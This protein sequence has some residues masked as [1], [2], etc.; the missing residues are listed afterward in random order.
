MTSAC[1]APEDQCNAAENIKGLTDFSITSSV[2][3]Y[4]VS[5]NTA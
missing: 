2:V 3:A 1:F 5:F 4:Q